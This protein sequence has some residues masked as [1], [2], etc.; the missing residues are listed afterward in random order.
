MAANPEKVAQM[1]AVNLTGALHFTQTVQA[2]LRPG[3][4]LA[5]TGSVAG[6]TGLPHGQIYSSAKA[7]AINLAET[8]RAELAGQT[9][10]RLIN[11]GFAQS[12]MTAQIDFDM[13]FIIRPDRAARDIIRGLDR[14]G[15]EVHFPLPL[16]WALKLLH[17]LP[18]WVL[19]PITKRLVR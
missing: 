6:Y 14:R 15:F 10:V 13:S 2:L 16:E 5:L 9:D 3:G 1:V 17:H 4:Q 18:C 12:R 8:L 7:G 19:I 11:P